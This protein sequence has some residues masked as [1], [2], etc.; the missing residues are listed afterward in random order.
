SFSLVGSAYAQITNSFSPTNVLKCFQH[1][2]A[3]ATPSPS[4]ASISSTNKN[5]STLIGIS[6]NN[7]G[8]K[9]LAKHKEEIKSSLSSYVNKTVDDLA[10]GHS[11]LG[12]YCLRFPF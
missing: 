6:I 9:D 11:R 5:V 2:C 8:L 12:T 7:T 4:P 3:P 10:G 1:P